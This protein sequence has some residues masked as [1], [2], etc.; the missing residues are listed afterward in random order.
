MS[1]IITC[2]IVLTVY[3]TAPTQSKITCGTVTSTLAQ[4]VSYLTNSGPLPSGCCTG[5]QSLNQMAQT[6]SD[7]RQVCECLK[8]AAKEINGFN[9]GLVATLPTTCGVSVPYP[10]SFSTNC[11]NISTAV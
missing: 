2:L 10:I 7:R 8:S 3:M 9:T 5:V 4:C 1:N 11:D 6:T